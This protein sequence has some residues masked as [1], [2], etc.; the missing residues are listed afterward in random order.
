M[1][2]PLLQC[3]LCGLQRLPALLF[4]H[5]SC[6]TVLAIFALFAC[7]MRM[8]HPCMPLCTLLVDACAQFAAGI[9]S[10]TLGTSVWFGG[11]HALLLAH[12]CGQDLQQEAIGIMSICCYVAGLQLRVYL[13]RQKR[14]PL[15][16]CMLCRCYS[17]LP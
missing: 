8:L 15:V 1:R 5:V 12:T 13:N 10:L 6:G 17:M 2:A 3:I 4:L 14:V 11:F 16:Q 7:Y 9:L